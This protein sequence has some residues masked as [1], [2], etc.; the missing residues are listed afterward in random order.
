[1]RLQIGLCVVAL[2][3]VAYAKEPKA[4]QSGKLVKMDSVE[5][6]TDEKDGQSVAAEIIG[7]DSGHR[8]TH[9]LLCQ[10]Y[11]L[12]D[13]KVVYRIRPRDEKHPALL[14]IGEFAQFRIEK[15]K[16]LLRVEGADEKEREFTV[17]SMTPRTDASSAD[18]VAPRVNHLQ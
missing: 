13:E 11:T 10:E 14:P 16:M 2:A 3:V 9:E 7:T 8:K 5:C 4:F 18:L 1:M 15:D 6:G 12:Q 17:V